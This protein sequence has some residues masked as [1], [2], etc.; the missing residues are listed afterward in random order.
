GRLSDHQRQQAGA[1]VQRRVFRPAPS[2]STAPSSTR[3]ATEYPSK[4]RPRGSGASAGL[5][6]AEPLPS[7]HSPMEPG[8]VWVEAP[9][10]REPPAAWPRSSSRT[11]AR[12]QSEEKVPAEARGARVAGGGGG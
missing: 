5:R 11:V 7:E 9:E 6:D 2:R 1:A 12:E 10:S 3:A 4:P 8:P